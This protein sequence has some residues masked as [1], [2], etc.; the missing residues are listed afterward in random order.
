MP[1]LENYL[2]PCIHSV[3]LC[4]HQLHTYLPPVLLSIN[5]NLRTHVHPVF[6]HVTACTSSVH[7]C[8]SMY[9]THTCSV[10]T[11]VLSTQRSQ[12]ATRAVPTNGVGL[13]MAG[14][15]SPTTPPASSPS[16]L[17]PHYNTQ[18]GGPVPRG[19][20]GESESSHPLTHAKSLHTV[21]RSSRFGLTFQKLT[22]GT[23]SDPKG[24]PRPSAIYPHRFGALVLYCGLLPN[25]F[26]A[27]QTPPL[28]LCLTVG[29]AN[30]LQCQVVH[31]GR[32]YMYLIGFN[33]NLSI[34]GISANNVEYH[35][36]C[37]ILHEITCE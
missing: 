20:R 17:I 35:N 1:P 4:T 19:V 36:T 22:R 11:C 26:T 13:A 10:C 2:P 32:I 30:R 12:N 24:Q 21:C 28:Q 14:P 3:R 27:I 31:S 18:S 34:L 5:T 16:L 8:N 6:I 9:L 15:L 23:T 25:I 7:T 33:Q 29:G 37:S